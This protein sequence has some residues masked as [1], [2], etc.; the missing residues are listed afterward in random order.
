[1]EPV[2]EATVERC[3]GLD[4]HQASVVACALVGPLGCKPRKEVRSFGTSTREL[5][6]LRA[7]LEGLGVTHVGM[8]STGAY[9]KPVHA[10][11][12]GR[13]E[14]IVGNAHHIKAVP[15][16]KTDV[17]DAEWLADLV[18]HGLIKPSFV[19][20]PP[21]RELRDL[22]RLRRSL[23]EARTTERNRT[24]KLL[25]TANIKLASV[26]SEVFGVSGMAMLRALVGGEAAPA[27]MAELA[28]GKLRRKREPLT[29]ALEGRLT[30]HHRY[31]LAFH[32]RRLAAIGGDLRALDARIEAKAEPFQAQRRLLQQIPGVD[33]LVAVTI[34][35]EVGVDMS[36]FGNAKRLAAWAGVCPGNHQSAGKRKGGAS[37]RGNVHL[38][39]ALVTAAVCGSRRKGS[40]YK[41]KYHR[42]K[43]RRGRLRAAV[44]IAHK[45]LVAAYHMLA[46]GVPFRELGEA[47]LDRQARQ[48]N[49][50][51]LLRRL[52]HLGYDVLLQPRAAEAAGP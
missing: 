15:G 3:A 26:A 27:E 51:H 7:W 8:E 38:K 40:Y 10:V 21:I 33:A 25:E 36:V 34:I 24:L 6:A 31:V 43:A 48:R 42:L 30:E 41:D 18:R 5:E 37:R 1:M 16:R 11:L 50:R 46:G 20:P 19:P 2:M 32:L 29:H 47:F 17:K 28:R 14:L 12:E 23:A 13:F 49:V 35:A 44:A 9:W 52:N 45:I 22:V 4:I 39:T